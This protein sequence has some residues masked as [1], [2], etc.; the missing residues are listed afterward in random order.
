MTLPST[1]ME[2]KATSLPKQSSPWI[3]LIGMYVRKNRGGQGGNDVS[4]LP[5]HLFPYCILRRT[6]N[7]E[8]REGFEGAQW[9]YNRH[10]LISRSWHV[11]CAD[12]Y[13]FCIYFKLHICVQC[14]FCQ[15]K[16]GCT[17]QTRWLINT[18][19]LKK[20]L[21][22]LAFHSQLEIRDRVVGKYTAE[23][24]KGEGKT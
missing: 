19:H 24:E 22:Y 4:L 2:E 10:T 23:P 12:F 14:S 1:Y 9:G 13:I 15:L 11:L 7:G 20:S 21:R 8:G 5:C 6:C 3:R 16:K 18:F 17:L